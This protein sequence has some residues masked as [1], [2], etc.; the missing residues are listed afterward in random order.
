MGPLHNK[1]NLH[2]DDL[3]YYLTYRM[4]NFYVASS[5]WYFCIIP[6]SHFL[7][8]VTILNFKNQ[9]LSLILKIKINE[10]M[11]M[12]HRL[13]AQSIN[14]SI[15]TYSLKSRRPLKMPSAIPISLKSP[16]EFS[17]ASNISSLCTGEMDA[18]EN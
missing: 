12:K 15:Q 6:S 17:K 9:N 14:Y 2:F 16:I 1:K 4:K 11:K 5:N 13:C 7:S 8:C 10:K 3:Q 18:M